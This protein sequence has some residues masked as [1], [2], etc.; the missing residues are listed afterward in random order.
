MDA[1][2]LLGERVRAFRKQH[3]LTQ[4]EMAFRCGMHASHITLLENG[5]RNPTLETLERLAE[6]MEIP[7]TDLLDYEKEPQTKCYDETTNKILAY[8][9]KLTAE[10]KK[11]VLIMAKALAKRTK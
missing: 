7:L 6:G 1:R 10:E 9:L 11:Q 5:N 3:G 2:Q 4:E 8:V